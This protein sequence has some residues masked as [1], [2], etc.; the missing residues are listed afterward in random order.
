MSVQTLEELYSVILDRLE[1]KP[2]GSYTAALAEK[3]IDHIARKV[4][5]EAVEVIVAALKEERLAEEAADLIYHLLVL[6]A[7]SGVGLKGMIEELDRRMHEKGLAT[8]ND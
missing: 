1:R 6:L 2:E 5:E 3:G 7:I 8:P 4:G